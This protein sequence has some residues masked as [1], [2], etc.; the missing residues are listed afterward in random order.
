MGRGSLMSEHQVLNFFNKKNC[1][2]TILP[3]RPRCL[4]PDGRALVIVHCSG[5]AGGER[6]L[7]RLFGRRLLRAF[8]HPLR[9]LK[10]LFSG[11]MAFLARKPS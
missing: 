3:G 6:T 1:P 4:K 2:D 10:R 9:A 7:L 8:R 11:A 5:M